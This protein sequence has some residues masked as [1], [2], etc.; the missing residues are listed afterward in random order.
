[1]APPVGPPHKLPKTVR[2]LMKFKPI[3]SAPRPAPFC[4]FRLPWDYIVFFIFFFLV[5]DIWIFGSF[6]F[7]F[8]VS[9]G[10]AGSSVFFIFFS[11]V[12][13]ALFSSFFLFFGEPSDLRF[14]HIFFFGHAGNFVF[15]VFCYSIC[16]A[17]CTCTIPFFPRSLISRLKLHGRCALH[18][19]GCARG[20]RPQVAKNGPFPN[21]I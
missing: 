6:V 21:E 20:V 4:E 12:I 17:W 7:S 11:S 13:P 8:F 3:L 9:S 15:P 16:C 19:R 2:F 5:G 18:L 1:M 10:I 14:L